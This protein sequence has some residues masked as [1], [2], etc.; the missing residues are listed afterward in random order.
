MLLEQAQNLGLK[1]QRHV[2]NLVE[3]ERAAV[4]PLKFTNAAAVCSGEGAL[5]VT[6]QFTFQQVL[7]DGSA[8]E[9]QEGCLGPGAVLV[10][11]TGDQFL[12]GAALAGNQHGDVL[13]GDAA[14]GLVHVAH[15]WA[16]SDDSALNVGVREGLRH[17]DRRAASPGHVQ[18]LA[19]HAPQLVQVK[20]LEEVV[21]G[22]LPH[23][24]DGLAR[25]LGSG[26]EDDRDARVDQA[27]RLVN[28]KTRLV[29]QAQVKKDD[30]GRFGTNSREPIR[31]GGGNLDLVRRGG[32]SLADLLRDQGR[33]IIDEHQVG[34]G[35]HSVCSVF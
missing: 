3:K 11:G 9:G 29:R 24:F 22:A 8:V 2:T 21:V 27:D 6:E 7:R 33:V 20:R 12:A 23:R 1:C 13:G 31:A 15:G 16:A 35:G 30:I 25:R 34:H 28:L 17:Y 14:D 10:D 5:L 19:D 4:A 32:K 18:C 26:D